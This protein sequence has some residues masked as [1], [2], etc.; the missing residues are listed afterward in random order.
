MTRPSKAEGD[1]TRPV[2]PLGKEEIG[3]RELFR[4]A[5]TAGV[6]LG[7]AASTLNTG[8]AVAQEADAP[9]LEKVPRRVL[10]STGETIPILLFGGDGTF[11]PQYDKMLHRGFRLGMNYLDTAESYANGQSHK[12]LGVFVEQAGRENLWITSKSGL[13]QRKATPEMY[14]KAIEEN[15]AGL[16]TDYLDMFMM[17]GVKDLEHLD[18]EFIKM[19]QDMKKSGFAKFFGFS[20]HD[21][22]V[23]ELMN[24]AAKIGPA[25][26]D[27]VMFKYSFALYG[28]LEL[29][30]AID[31]CQSAGIG[32]IAMKAQDATL[33]DRDEVKKFQ[34]ENFTLGQAKLKAVWADERIS[35]CTSGMTN[36]K[37]LRENSNAARSV[38]QLAM[39]EF[40]QLNRYA[41]RTAGSRCKFCSHICESQIDGNT[42]VAQALRYLMYDECYGEHDKAR[43]LYRALRPDE[44]DFHNVDLA[45]ATASCPQGID[46]PKRLERAQTRLAWK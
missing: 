29:N 26:I 2:V 24:K 15:I 45:Q 1:H 25:G 18:P 7:A 19:G 31:A 32:L 38:K 34:S 8:A 4:R 9:L 40:M 17:H 13:F 35:G 37:L 21:G 41:A 30:K 28:D 20:C 46:I 5:A 27:A 12:T 33:Q 3:R 42:R 22:N 39:S 11:D 14:R 10:G 6:G 44:R 43:Q 36:M 23:V 16:R